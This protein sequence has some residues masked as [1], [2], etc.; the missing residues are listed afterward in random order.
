MEGCTSPVF[1]FQEETLGKDNIRLAVVDE[2]DNLDFV[3]KDDIILLRTASKTLVDAIRKKGIRSTAEDYDSYQLALDKKALTDFLRERRI[4]VAQRYSIPDIVDGKEYF[5]K[6]RNGSDSK[7]PNQ[8][9]CRKKEEVEYQI[10]VIAETFGQDAIIEDYLSGKEYTV[11]CVKIG[12]DI[13]AAPI[14]I[15]KPFKRML[16]KEEDSVRTLALLAFMNLG[17]KHHARID[18]RSGNDGYPCVIDVNLIPGL[19]PSDKWTKCFEACN[20]SYHDS[21]IMVINSASIG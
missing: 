13:F 12:C 11:A 19:G 9:I 7:I 20:M 8:G 16:P 2:S 6:P 5:V 21:L 15:N 18:I 14:D 4:N 17:L 10:Q 1:K 3:G